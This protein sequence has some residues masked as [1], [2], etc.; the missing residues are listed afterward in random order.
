M[1]IQAQVLNLLV[2][3]REQFGLTYLFIAHD[4]SVVRTSATAW[5]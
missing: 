1:S 3:L 4:L 5:R 2:D